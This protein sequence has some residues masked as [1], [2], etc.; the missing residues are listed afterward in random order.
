VS[1]PLPTAH[2]EAADHHEHHSD[3]V[4]PDAI[5]FA[6]VHLAALGVFFTGFT[7]T[8]IILCI[9]FYFVRMW[10]VTA[11]YHRYFSH[12]S[13]KT[14]RVGQF[15]LA[16]LAQMTAQKG[17]LWW[18]AIHRHHHLHSDTPED[19]HSPRHHGFF[20]SHVG[21]IFSRTKSKPDY[22]TIPDLTKYPELVF[23]NR[24]QHIPAVALAVFCFLV[25]GWA[26][27][28]VG[29][30]LSTVL[31]YHGTFTINSLA[32]VTGSQRYL[33][34]DDSRN[35]WLLAIIT[36]GE[37]WHNNHH[38][39]QSSA[40]QGFR[41]WEFDPTYYILKMLSWTGVVWGIREPPAAIVRGEAPV[42]RKALEKVAD[43]VV[44]S[45]HPDRIVASIRPS[46]A[47]YTPLDDL[48]VAGERTRERVLEWL[49]EVQLPHLPSREALR[50]RVDEM[51]AH[52]PSPDEVVERAREILLDRIAGGLLGDP[53]SQPA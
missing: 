2:A 18:A 24:F 12:R 26:G 52:A 11:G 42:G 30:F 21:W 41:W 49:Q 28:F 25:D 43:S 7:R 17:A 8:S 51:F 46:F 4:Y 50:E 39:Y 9:T 45:F 35:N 36:M 32:H 40:R 31:V 6:M 34:G 27:L 53:G 23:L 44:D 20:F 38:H 19:I 1:H 14:S 5:P 29:F 47:Q 3:V 10:A 22:S 15:V 48:R 37:G 16:F 13:Y 33:T